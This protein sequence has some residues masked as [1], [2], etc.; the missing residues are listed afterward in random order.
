MNHSVSLL[1]GGVH[2]HNASAS[3]VKVTHN[4]TDKGFGNRD[5]QFAHRLK[6]NR[7]SLQQTLLV[8][9]LSRSLEGNFIGINRMVRAIVQVG[10][11]MSHRESGCA[12]LH[13]FKQ[14]LFNRRVEVLR[15]NTAND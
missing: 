12:L 3:L 8:S 10:C 9:K 13:C 15:N 4:I 11:K 7:S 5:I 14:T 2:T 1:L 6:N